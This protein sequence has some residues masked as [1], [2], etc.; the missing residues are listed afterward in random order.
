MLSG[1]LPFDE[2]TKERLEHR[3]RS[4][5]PPLPL[6]PTCPEPLGRIVFKMLSRDPARRYRSATEMKED[7]IRFRRMEPVKAEAAPIAASGDDGEATVR[8]AKPSPGP[9]VWPAAG[10]TP[11]PQPGSPPGPWQGPGPS[12]GEG[13][14]R[15]GP[16]KEPPIMWPP[17]GPRSRRNA[18]GCL[19]AAAVAGILIIAF[20]AAQW[21]FWNDADALKNDLQTERISVSDGWTRYEALLKRTHLPFFLWGAQS[22]LKKRLLAAAD[23]TIS[24]YRSNDE[25]AVYEAHWVE[26]RNDL[27]QAMQL[28]P[29]DNAVKGRLRLSEGHLDRINGEPQYH[30]GI[31]RPYRLPNRKL[32]NSA[33]AKFNEAADLLKNWPDPYLG[34]ARLYIFDLDDLDK[35]EAALNRAAELGHPRGK[36]E[37]AL[38][39]DGFLKRADRFWANS[40]TR[41]NSPDQERDSLTKADQDYK[42]AQELYDQVRLLGDVERNRSLAIAGQERVA[43]R[44]RALQ[45]QV[46]GIPP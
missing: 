25:P 8:T 23:A 46:P 17:K 44:L 14:Y 10:P 1:N 43:E 5:E 28:D 4:S 32:L 29:G 34:L 19:V 27:N 7:L 13:T 6:P 33:V 35:G 22:A 18:I 21:N 11:W 39:A 16:I 41:G 9:A 42:H 12:P 36:R 45:F 38:L 2:T 40:Q 37:I 3:I 15:T 26:A 24:E 30:R 31:A 20:V